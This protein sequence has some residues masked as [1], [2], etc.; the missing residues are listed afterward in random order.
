LGG[1]EDPV[2]SVILVCHTF[3]QSGSSQVR[4]LLDPSEP[5]GPEAPLG[6]FGFFFARK[7]GLSPG[8]GSCLPAPVELQQ[9]FFVVEPPVAATVVGGW[10]RGAERCLA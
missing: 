5:A 3:R 2:A 6:S 4:T 10:I 1:R 9:Q 8:R 7:P